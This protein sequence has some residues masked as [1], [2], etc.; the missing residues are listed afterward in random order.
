MSAPILALDPADEITSAL[1]RLDECW[2]YGHGEEYR[3]RDDDLMALHSLLTI[4]EEAEL[5]AT[6]LTTPSGAEL[7][8]L[9]LLAPP[10]ALVLGEVARCLWAQIA[11][12]AGASCR[13]LDRLGG[14]VDFLCRCAAHSS[15]TAAAALLPVAEHGRNPV[16]LDDEEH[17]AYRDFA[18]A[19]LLDPLDRFIALG[20]GVW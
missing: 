3:I 2:R 12:P 9:W 10:A 19:V 8:P 14:P 6:P 17:A 18:I 4:A 1:R 5:C 15:T 20:E 13:H 7:A 16:R 11:Q